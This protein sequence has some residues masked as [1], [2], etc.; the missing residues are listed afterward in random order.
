MSLA[1]HILAG[2]SLFL[3]PSKYPAPMIAI[4]INMEINILGLLGMLI[5]MA[6]ES[7]VVGM[8]FSFRWFSRRQEEIPASVN[9]CG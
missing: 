4:T 5:L 1:P 7:F 2:R 3:H 6:R 8:D 9:A